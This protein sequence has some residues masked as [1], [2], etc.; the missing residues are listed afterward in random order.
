MPCTGSPFGKLTSKYSARSASTAASLTTRSTMFVL[1][2][3]RATAVIVWSCRLGA[4]AS[5]E[6]APAH[7]ARNNRKPVDGRVPRKRARKDRENAPIAAARRGVEFAIAIRFSTSHLSRPRRPAEGY[8]SLH[9]RTHYAATHPSRR[10]M[11]LA[12]RQRDDESAGIRAAMMGTRKNSGAR[13][14]C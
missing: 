5:T 8:V 2:P 3:S 6:E 4:A 13:N 10:A 7:S 1:P 9:D 11:P 14:P 12:Y